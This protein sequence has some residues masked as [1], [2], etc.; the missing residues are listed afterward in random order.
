MS[1]TDQKVQRQV[2]LRRPDPPRTTP[3]RNILGVFSQKADDGPKSRTYSAPLSQTEGHPLGLPAD[4]DADQPERLSLHQNKQD[5]DAASNVIERHIEETEK[6]TIS[7]DPDTWTRLSSLAGKVDPN[8]IAQI[9][10]VVTQSY[11]E[12][13]SM[14]VDL[15]GKLREVLNVQSTSK[16]ASGAVPL[17]EGL[18]VCI[19]SQRRVSAKVRMFEAGP[20]QRVQ[21]LLAEA[22]EQ[23]AMIRDVE[24]DNGQINILVQP[25]IGAG[26]YHGMLLS[27]ENK[28]VGA[29][30]VTVP[31]PDQVAP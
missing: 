31:N 21:P 25:D 2:R 15:A 29:I 7:A 30:T 1:S 4:M 17:P 12:V 24:F 5:M 18:T 9:A 14:W 13:A 8:D 22:A 6:Y 27:P 20:I 16:E 28:P 10:K 3:H 11:S 23:T 19:Q 26:T